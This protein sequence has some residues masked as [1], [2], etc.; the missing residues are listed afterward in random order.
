VEAGDDGTVAIWFRGFEPLI[1]LRQIDTGDER[2]Q[3]TVT[4][5]DV[6]VAG[7][8]GSIVFG[9]LEACERDE[10]TVGCGRGLLL[11]VH[12]LRVIGARWLEACVL[13]VIC[14]GVEIIARR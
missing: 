14:G 1:E 3:D 9:I 6:E 5:V 4:V 10:R 13:R 12:P 7:A 2:V 8:T 11:R